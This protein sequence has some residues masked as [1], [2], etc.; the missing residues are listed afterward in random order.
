[1]VDGVARRSVGSAGGAL[2]TVWLIEAIQV[3]FDYPKSRIVCQP[4]RIRDGW[5]TRE[6]SFVMFLLTCSSDSRR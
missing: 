4:F 6:M 1:M 2:S 5:T 3:Q